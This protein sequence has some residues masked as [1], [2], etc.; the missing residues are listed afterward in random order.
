MSRSALA[1][2]CAAAALAAS[3]AL[4]A[5]AALI[6][7]SVTAPATDADDIY[8]LGAPTTGQAVWSDRP[9]QG[10]TFTTSAAGGDLV[11]ITFQLDEGANAPING[12][13][14][15]QLR[16]GTIDLGNNT[17]TPLV[18]TVDRYTPDADNDSYFT[19]TLD[20]PLSL[21]PNTLYGFD[22]GVEA[23][24]TGWQ[25]GIPSIRITGDDYAGGQRYQGAKTNLIDNTTGLPN[26]IS[27]TSGDLVF[28]LN[29]VPEP[30][31]LALMG[32][33][34]L[35]IARRRRA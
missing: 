1:P 21:A 18:V 5:D 12:W 25:S 29:I 19:I 4:S 24:Q 11:A 2:V 31:S 10:Q 23:S 3:F 7:N 27:P 33:G 16:I 20:T 14:D 9:V 35:L 13:K 34:G 26:S 30:G 8:N 6:T 15:Y 32:L 17:I 22:I 28:H